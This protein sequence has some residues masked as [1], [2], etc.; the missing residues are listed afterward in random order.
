MI[1]EYYLEDIVQLLNYK[2]DKK[3][4]KKPKNSEEVNCNLLV[5]ATYPDEVRERVARINEDDQQ[6]Q[7]IEVVY[8]F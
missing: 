7:I 4:L 2:P 6:L 1:L 3:K 8:G 5:P